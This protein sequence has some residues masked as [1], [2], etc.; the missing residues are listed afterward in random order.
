M[1]VTEMGIMDIVVG[2][3]KYGLGAVE[4]LLKHERD[5]VVVDVDESC[6]VQQKYS[7]EVIDASIK[8]VKGRVFV[9][10]GIKEVL[11]L[12]EELRPEYVFPTAPIHIAAALLTEKYGFEPWSEGVD[13]ILPGL[14]AKVVVSVGRGSVTVSYN[15]DG[16]CLPKCRAPD[17][18]PVTG[19]KKPAPMYEMLRFAA[20][21]GF[22]IQSHYL[23]PGLGALQGEDVLDLLEWASDKREAVVGTACRCHGVVTALIR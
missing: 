23:E 7:F 20:P 2:G 12:I 5:F 13:C 15:R 10:G 17:V 22:I 4:Y 1:S 8:P 11:R 18:C 19:V 3:G 21:D 6:L 14:P 9:R 16:D